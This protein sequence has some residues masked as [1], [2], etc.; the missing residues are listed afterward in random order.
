[1][2]VFESALPV[3]PKHSDCNPSFKKEEG[4]ELKRDWLSSHSIFPE[5]MAMREDEI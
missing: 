1:M 2:K 4:R 5:K 3:P